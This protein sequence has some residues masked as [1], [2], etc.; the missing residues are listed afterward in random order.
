M[1]FMSTDTVHGGGF[2]KAGGN[3]HLRLQLWFAKDERS[4]A[5]R[6]HNRLSLPDANAADKK[7]DDCVNN[8]AFVEAMYDKTKWLGM[9]GF[10]DKK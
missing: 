8:Y 7:I 9:W 6:E 10:T 2:Q 5:A 4:E 1:L 3:G